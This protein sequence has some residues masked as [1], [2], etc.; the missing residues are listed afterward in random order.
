MLKQGEPPTVKSELEWAVPFLQ[1]AGI[2]T[3]RLEA[4]VLLAHF[5]G[6]DRGRLMSRIHDQVAGGTRE[7]F[8]LAVKKRGMRYPLQYLT[9]HQEFMSLDFLVNSHV[10]IPRDDTETL[11]QAVLALKERVPARPAIIDVGTG[12]GIIAVCLKKYWPEA[13]LT[14]ADISPE[15]LEVARVNARRN[16]VDVEFCRSDL[17]D[18][19]AEPR[20]HI[21]V[22]NPPYISA[23]EMAGLQEELA[24]EPRL[25]VYGG[26]DGLDFY[27]RL[28][29]KSAGLL[30][31]GGWLAVEIGSKQGI[32]VK[33]LLELH[34]YTEIQILQDFASLDRVVLGRTRRDLGNET[35]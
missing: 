28:T 3:A 32:T 18:A 23:D 35:C 2:S 26:E 33:K 15:A 4:E 27:R 22:S 9:G 25:A 29:V 31:P 16:H 24:F 34:G 30:L 14:A 13:Q 1:Q 20:F 19:F 12:S 17:L 11:V 8:R 5:L 21:V 7:S 10:L 6:W